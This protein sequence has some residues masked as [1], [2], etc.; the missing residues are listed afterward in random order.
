MVNQHH[1]F[2]LYEYWMVIIICFI[3]VG[4]VL[5]T[6]ISKGP[7]PHFLR[8]FKIRNIAFARQYKHYNTWAGTL[9]KTNVTTGKTYHTYSKITSEQGK[10]YSTNNTHHTLWDG[11]PGEFLETHRVGGG[12]TPTQRIWWLRKHLVNEIIPS[13]DARIVRRFHY[14]TRA[15]LIKHSSRHRE[16]KLLRSN[17]VILLY[18]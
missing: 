13:I 15:L 14:S 7:R 9:P 5:A 1:L 6:A 17:I 10:T 8:A 11:F 18:Q 4:R 3:E 2:F 12:G 16:N